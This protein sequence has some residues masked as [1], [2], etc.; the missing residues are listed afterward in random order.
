MNSYE[1]SNQIQ[2]LW[3]EVELQNESVVQLR[4]IINQ[5]LEYK[6]GNGIEA[7]L[8]M[9]VRIAHVRLIHHFLGQRLLITV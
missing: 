3:Q 6:S 1:N 4:K 7:E 5:N 2:L 9:L 8:A